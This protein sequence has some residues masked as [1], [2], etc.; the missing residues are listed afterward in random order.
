MRMVAST[1]LLLRELI[2]NT[3]NDNTL[4]GEWWFAA[5][6]LRQIISLTP[7]ATALIVLLSYGRDE[8][9]SSP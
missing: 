4:L 9:C 7:A 5:G 1:G 3:F 8:F 2:L 6:T